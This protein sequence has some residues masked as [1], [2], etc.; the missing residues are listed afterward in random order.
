M[1]VWQVMVHIITLPKSKFAFA[2]KKLKLT[3][4]DS[5]QKDKFLYS[6][7]KYKCHQIQL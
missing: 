4:K 2:K 1:E 6:A 3:W 5:L 7:L